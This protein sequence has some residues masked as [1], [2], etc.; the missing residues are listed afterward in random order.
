MQRVCVDVGADTDTLAT[1]K[2]VASVAV[3]MSRENEK[4]DEERV[5]W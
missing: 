2:F 3:L 1:G 5:E 4:I